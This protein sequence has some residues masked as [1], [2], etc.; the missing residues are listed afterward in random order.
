MPVKFYH[1]QGV[2]CITAHPGV[3]HFVIAAP[4]GDKSA[5]AFN[6]MGNLL[7]ITHHIIFRGGIN[8]HLVL[9]F[10]Q[11]GPVW[12]NF[13]CSSLVRKAIYGVV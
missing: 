9:A 8:L 3:T 12:L 2:F 6:Q 10:R 4:G 11:I 7:H 13:S 1:M 5:K